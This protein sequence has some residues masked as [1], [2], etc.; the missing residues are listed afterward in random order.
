[1]ANNTGLEIGYLLTVENSGTPI[2]GS[3]FTVPIGA[4]AEEINE[5]TTYNV[6][7]GQA[8]ALIDN[9]TRAGATCLP[10]CLD[11]LTADEY[12]AEIVL[13]TNVGESFHA[14]IIDTR[15]CVSHITY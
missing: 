5:L 11:G 15:T 7:I 1:M 6:T 12:P 8:Q 2:S 3:P 10:I 4:T 9:R 13:N 14:M